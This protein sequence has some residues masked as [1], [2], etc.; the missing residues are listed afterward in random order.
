[1]FLFEDGTTSIPHITTAAVNQYVGQADGQTGVKDIAANQ[2]AVILLYTDGTVKAC[3]FNLDQQTVPGGSNPSQLVQV[4]AA[5]V[6]VKSIVASYRS[7]AC[8][9][10]DKTVIS[11]GAN[12]YYQSCPLAQGT[13]YN[14]TYIIDRRATPFLSNVKEIA[15]GAYGTAIL[16]E[17]GTIVGY[18]KNDNYG[19]NPGANTTPWTNT[20]SSFY[21]PTVTTVLTLTNFS[22]AITTT[23]PTSVVSKT[24]YMLE[25]SNYQVVFDGASGIT[26]LSNTQGSISPIVIEQQEG[27][28]N[29][30]VVS[31]KIQLARTN[32][33]IAEVVGGKLIVRDEENNFFKKN[34]TLVIFRGDTL[35]RR[36]VS[37]IV[38]SFDSI[39]ELYITEITLDG[40]EADGVV[41]VELI[42]FKLYSDMFT[43]TPSYAETNLSVI[44]LGANTLEFSF[45]KEEVGTKFG[46]YMDYD[47]T[48]LVE[49]TVP[50][51]EARL[52]TL[53]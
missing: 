37:S 13:Y 52:F 31:F 36:K 22:P 40:V 28:L 3:G 2:Q 29:F 21:S 27:Q 11:W 17:D 51:V 24:S 41:S 19:V 15:N 32:T 42:P 47:N 1:M 39:S 53:Q 10:N 6:G 50:R 12:S 34:D 5:S 46:F 7:V 30:A 4:V 18:G 9:L 8:V 38:N 48:D 14:S 33:F 49:H 20:S 23:T 16:F 35:T 26:G 25:D 43:D 45:E 44:S